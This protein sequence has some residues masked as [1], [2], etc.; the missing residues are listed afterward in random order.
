MIPCYP[1]SDR[2]FVP[3]AQTQPHLQKVSQQVRYETAALRWRVNN[4]ATHLCVLRNILPLLPV[5]VS[6]NIRIFEIH[7]F[8]HDTIGADVAVLNTLPDLRTVVLVPVGNYHRP[9]VDSR[10][11]LVKRWPRKGI[12]VKETDGTVV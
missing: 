9:P 3:L 1:H 12:Q 10:G 2:Q 4:F 11:A 7:A 6:K 8:E 5:S